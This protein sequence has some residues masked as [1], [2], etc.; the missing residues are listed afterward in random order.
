[1]RVTGDL[2]RARGDDQMIL[3]FFS[4]MSSHTVM[5]EF[6]ICHPIEPVASILS[7][8]KT[9]SEVVRSGRT[10]RARRHDKHSRA[11]W[12]KSEDTCRAAS[13]ATRRGVRASAQASGEC[14]ILPSAPNGTRRAIR[15][16]ALLCRRRSILRLGARARRSAG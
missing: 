1:V 5:I 6:S 8:A 14:W 13:R 11:A 3:R 4:E 2:P 16:A 7:F 12:S 15:L 9:V 10:G